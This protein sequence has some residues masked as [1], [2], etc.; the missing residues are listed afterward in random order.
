MSRIVTLTLTRHGA[1]VAAV[2]H[3]LLVMSRDNVV[4]N[5]SLLKYFKVE[6]I[7]TEIQSMRAS[8][9][10]LSACATPIPTMSLAEVMRNAD[11]LCNCTQVRS[12]LNRKAV[13]IVLADTDTWA[14]YLAAC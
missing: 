2:A 12:L 4:C 10:T 13:L 5:R 6:A 7:F 11:L 3:T 9:T 14:A 8:G 1:A